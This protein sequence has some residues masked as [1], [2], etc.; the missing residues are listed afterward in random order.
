MGLLRLTHPTWLLSS[1]LERGGGYVA[2]ILH[3]PLSPLFRG[4]CTKD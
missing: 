3:T 1:P 2:A 4:E